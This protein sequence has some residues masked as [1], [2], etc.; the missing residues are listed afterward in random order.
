MAHD[1][2]SLTS[3]LWGD[4]MQWPSIW[5]N[6]QREIP[7]IVLDIERLIF[8]DLITEVVRGEVAPHPGKHCR[9]LLFL[10]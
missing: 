2:E 9:Q 6:G 4:F 10:K 3:L 8:K 7:D 5:T 1:D